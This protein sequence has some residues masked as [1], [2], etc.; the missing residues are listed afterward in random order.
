MPPPEPFYLNQARK[1]E[2]QKAAD[3][4]LKTADQ[5]PVQRDIWESQLKISLLAAECTTRLAEAGIHVEQT[6]DFD[7][8]MWAID[9][10]G[11]PYLTDFMSPTKNDFFEE[12]CFWLLLN[13]SN[14]KPAGLTGARSDNTGR[15]PLSAYSQR[16][17]RNMFPEEKHVPIRGDRLPRVA[18]E[19]MG[20]VVYTGD[21]FI[22]PEIRSTS[23]NHLRL[24]VM[25]L[26]C[27]TYLKWPKLDWLYAFLRDRDVKRGAA[28]MYHFPRVY[29]MAHSWT[30]PPSDASGNNWIAAMNRVEM[31]DLFATY[32]GATDRL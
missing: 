12:N 21:L 11:K 7:Y 22:G 14:G 4:R 28:W 2:E 5:P 32:F 30:S 27:V 9:C 29:P 8:V 13:D 10:V 15:E 31:V 17:L 6:T 23:R 1:A 18:D 16:K 24:L 3:Q 19:I 20:H 25:L 26:Y